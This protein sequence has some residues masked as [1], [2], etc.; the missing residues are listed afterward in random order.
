[1]KIPNKTRKNLHFTKL[2]QLK[3]PF[4]NEQIRTNPKYLLF[5]FL[6]IN[7][8]NYKNNLNIY[9]LTFGSIELNCK[10]TVF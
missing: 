7:R 4:N 8:E 10:N 9:K 1:M 3:V 2:K 6:Y 5:V